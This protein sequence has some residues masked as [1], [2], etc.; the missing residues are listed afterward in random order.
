[1]VQG[2]VIRQL[3]VT[4]TGFAMERTKTV[5]EF[6]GASVLRVA[7]EL[8]A[9]AHDHSAIRVLGAIRPPSEECNST[10]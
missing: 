5:S 8:G 4:F 2:Q 6:A 1:M 7:I 3:T 9:G 10:W